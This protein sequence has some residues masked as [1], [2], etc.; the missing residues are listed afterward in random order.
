MAYNILGVNPGHNGSVALVSDGKLVYF[1]EEER[2]SREKYDGNPFRGIIDILK[3]WHIDEIVIGGTS[4]EL[5]RLPWTGEDPYTALVRKSC[6]NVKT[7]IFGHEHHLGHAAHTFYNSGFERAA[8]IIIDGAGSF[9]H[10]KLDE[11]GE[12][13]VGHVSNGDFH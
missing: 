2:L 13:V 7:T 12:V 6:P 8:V 4:P 5:P 1:I 11:Q 3:K 10:E 9:R